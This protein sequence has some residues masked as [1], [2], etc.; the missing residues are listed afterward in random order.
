MSATIAK[1]LGL[2]AGKVEAAL[3]AVRPARGAGPGQGAPP[4][5]A[6]PQAGSASSSSQTTS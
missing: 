1:Q 6:A 5:S 2:S 4:S 3:Q